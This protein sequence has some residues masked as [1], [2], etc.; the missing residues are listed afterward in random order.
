MKEKNLMTDIFKYSLGGLGITLVTNLVMTY[1][2]F[3]LTDIF[4]ITTFAVAGI[5]LVSR[6]VDAITDPL[7]GIIADRTH[8]RW[9]KFRPWLMFFAP[10]L[11]VAIFVLFYSPQISESMKVI[12]AYAVFILY[13]IIV[14]IVSIPYFALVPVLSKDAHTRTII[15][16]WKSVM[17][18]VAVLCIS[19]FALPIVN[20]FGGGQKGW[21]SFGALIGIVSTLLI[22]V[23]A[24]GA[25]T[26]DVC[27]DASIKKTK[28]KTTGKDISVLFKTKPL[29]L[30]IVAFGLS[31][32]ANTLLNSANMYYFKYVLHKENWIPT[33]M[34]VTM[35]AGILASMVLPKLEAKFGKRNLFMYTSILCA[36]P[37]FIIGF[38]PTMGMV[39]LSVLLVVFGFFYGLVSAL[40]WAMVPD[41]IDFAQW[42]YGV[43]P[44]GLFTA[45]FTFIQKCA[46]A[47]GGFLSGILLGFAGFIANQEQ[48]AQALQ[49]IIN[50]RF[51]IP[52]VLFVLT[53]LALYF[54]EITPKKTKEIAAELEK[55]NNN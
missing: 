44:N 27:I 12:Y 33:V 46:T 7:M 47:I 48:S 30:L 3:F 43:Q 40:P 18:Q 31:F 37:L 20:A 36:I 19:V 28:E 50:L 45:T 16:S 39:G 9:G 26:H 8:S 32:L 54:Y 38:M 14:T 55:R 53:I 23:A 13:S 6:I 22:W 49:M 15:I 17:C 5:M 10:V 29:L 11:G 52:A 51:F 42:K 35:S 1:F 25:K 34:F 21:A 41:C 4:G 24:S 2:N